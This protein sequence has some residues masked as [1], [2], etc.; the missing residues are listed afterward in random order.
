ML[1]DCSPAKAAHPPDD[2]IP[3]VDQKPLTVRCDATGDPK[4]VVDWYRDGATLLRN[5][6]R[7]QILSNGSLHFTFAK[8]SDLGSYHCVVSSTC[9][10]PARYKTKLVFASEF[11]GT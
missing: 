7:I 5:T 2:K 3:F 11:Q 6:S 1:P 10:K 9:Y 4:P 8:A